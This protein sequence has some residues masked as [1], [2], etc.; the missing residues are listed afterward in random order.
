[1]SGHGGAGAKDRIPHA[2]CCDGNTNT[3][4]ESV[5]DGSEVRISGCGVRYY[6]G[7]GIFTQIVIWCNATTEIGCF[8]GAL[9][10]PEVIAAVGVKHANDGAA[11]SVAAAGSA[12]VDQAAARIRGATIT[13]LIKGSVGTGLIP[14][15]VAAERIR[16]ADQ[17]AACRIITIR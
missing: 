1:M 16:N 4:R 17:V 11:F 7:N 10:V 13:A 3:N 15:G 2:R 14:P 12:V 9:T 5:I 6:D 8:I